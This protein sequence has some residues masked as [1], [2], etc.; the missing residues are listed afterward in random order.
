[1][2]NDRKL[3][4]VSRAICAAAGRY[5]TPNVPYSEQDPPTQER[6]PCKHCYN[7]VTK[8]EECNMWYTFKSEAVAAITAIKG[9]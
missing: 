7:E 3:E 2:I 9:F 1:M 8:K 5:D 6:R 4:R